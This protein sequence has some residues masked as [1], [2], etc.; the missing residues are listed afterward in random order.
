[1]TSL[2][3]YYFGGSIGW[4]AHPLL[5][6]TGT[7]LINAGDASALLLPHADWSLSDDMSLVFGGVF[8]IGAGLRRDG[9]PGSEYGG[10]PETIY[11]AIKV[12]F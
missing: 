12:Y 10:V 5:M 6:L 9:R 8:G 1:V 4:Q 7:T 2:G 3:R 11:G